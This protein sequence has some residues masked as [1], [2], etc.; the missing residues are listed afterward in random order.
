VADQGHPVFRLD[1][2]A[3]IS[4]VCDSVNSSGLWLVLQ[5]VLVFCICRIGSRDKIGPPAITGPA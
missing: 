5:G 1:I 3:L 4:Y 2:I